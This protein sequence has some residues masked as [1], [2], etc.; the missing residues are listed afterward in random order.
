M[1]FFSINSITLAGSDNYR[2]VCDRGIV[3]S[4]IELIG[5]VVIVKD[6]EP[7]IVIEL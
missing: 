2:A 1:D 7:A 4:D 3:F 5:V 6:E